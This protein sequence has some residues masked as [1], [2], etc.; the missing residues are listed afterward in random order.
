LSTASRYGQ[1]A[2]LLEVGYEL[3]PLSPEAS[4]ESNPDPVD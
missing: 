1:Q 3:N 2:N 4:A